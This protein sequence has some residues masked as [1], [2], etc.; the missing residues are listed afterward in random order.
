[1]PLAF[2]HFKPT[3]YWPTYRRTILRLCATHPLLSAYVEEANNREFYFVQ[4]MPLR[5]QALFY[6]ALK[7][8]IPFPI[9]GFCCTDHDDRL[10]LLDNIQV[11]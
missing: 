4:D 5:F 11:Q 6:E 1:V 3:D 10:R 7:A 9:W 2:K 8:A